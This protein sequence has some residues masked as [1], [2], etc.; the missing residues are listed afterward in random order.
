MRLRR[1]AVSNI[2]SDFPDNRPDESFSGLLQG[3]GFR[4]ERICSR[5]H[6]SPPGFWYDQDHAEWV[7]VLKGTA[8]LQFEG[9]DEITLSPGDFVLIGAHERH[10]VN[11]TAPEETTVWLAIHETI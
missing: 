5:G 3:Q 7:M 6:A 2:F 4:V 1:H 11:W 8:G 10:R 9:E